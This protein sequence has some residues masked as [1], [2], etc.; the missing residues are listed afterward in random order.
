MFRRIE[1]IEVTDY[2]KIAKEMRAS[3]WTPSRFISEKAKNAPLEWTKSGLCFNSCAFE[4]FKAW[5]DRLEDAITNGHK[6]IPNKNGRFYFTEEGW[7]KVGRFVIDACIQT[8]TQYR[9]LK[10]KE[11]EMDVLYR[12]AYEVMLRP[13]K[14]REGR[15]EDKKYQGPVA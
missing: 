8:K 5:V 9:V 4:V 7:D 6:G 3:G 15:R 11:K 14:K 10:V 1:L 13:R 12:N 2:R